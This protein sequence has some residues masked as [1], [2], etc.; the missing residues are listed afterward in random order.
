M[1]PKD[2]AEALNDIDPVLVE[3]AAPKQKKKTTYRWLAAAACLV[4]LVGVGLLRPWQL[5]RVDLGGVTRLY[6]AYAPRTESGALIFPWEYR[7]LYDQYHAMTLADK[8][9][10][11]RANTISEDLLGDYLGQGEAFGYDIYTDSTNTQEFPVYAIVGIDPKLLVAVEQ[12]G[13]YY[14]FME[15]TYDPPATLGD[16]LDGYA[17]PATLTL[18]RFGLYDTYTNQGHYRLTDPQAA[19]A[20]IWQLLSGCREAAYMEAE[21]D[22]PANVGQR[23]SFAATSEPLGIYKKGISISAGGYLDTNIA[24]Y[25]YVYYIGEDTATAII[26]YVMENSRK[27]KPE[28]YQYSVAGIIT[29]ICDGY[30]LLDDSALAAGKGMVFRVPTDDLR[31]SRWLD[32]GRVEIGDVVS[33][34]YTGGIADSTVQDPVDLSPAIL[35]DG[36]VLIPE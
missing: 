34:T 16:F 21:F 19:S 18:D 30:F 3:E 1:N 5:H 13:Q 7:P 20:Y 33:V 11:T 31:I 22:S 8:A 24:E 25:G 2:I 27:A 14:V 32:F 6:R 26:D 29:E 36:Y 9:Y 35:E 23:I 12:G 28:P 4:L 17:L 15:E 10:R